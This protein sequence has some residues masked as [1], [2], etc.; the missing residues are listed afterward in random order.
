MRMVE[1]VDELFNEYQTGFT[2][3]AFRW[4]KRLDAAVVVAAA[5][6]VVFAAVAAFAFEVASTAVPVAAAA[7]WQW[8]IE[9][10]AVGFEQ[11]GRAVPFVGSLPAWARA[12][13][14]WGGPS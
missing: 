8:Q 14:W 3:A 10:S 1:Q 12:R 7:Y 11:P 2:A 13:P 5:A 6:V 9:A 4:L